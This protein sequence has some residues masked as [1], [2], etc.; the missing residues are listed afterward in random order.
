MD[1]G[2]RRH[3]G[4]FLAVLAASTLAA[5]APAASA[6][7][8]DAGDTGK[9]VAIKGAPAPGPAAYDRVWVRKYGPAN[10]G[11]VLILMPGS[12]SGQGSFDAI[13]PEI[14]ERVPGLAVWTLDRRGNAFEDVSAFEL[15]D[16]NAA[17]SYYLLEQ[18]IGGR[19]FQPV[20]D[21]DARFVRKW[22]AAVAMNDVHRV[23][24]RAGRRG[25]SVILGGHSMGASLTPLY[26]AWD[27]R[28]R[29]G[30]RDLD[31]LVQI[32]GGAM[33]TWQKSTAGTPFADRI[34]SVRKAKRVLKAARGQSP[35]GFA[36]WIEGVPEWLVGVLPELGCQYA[37]QAP[38]EASVFQ[39]LADEVEAAFPGVLPAGLL[40]EFPVTNEA[41]IGYLMTNQSSAGIALE[42]L[43]A[44]VGQLAESGDPRPW[45][46][47]PISSV[48]VACQSFTSE[49]GNA[50]EWYYPVRLE[51][52]VL[53]GDPYLSGD[54]ASRYLGMRAFHLSQVDVPVYAYE[55]A[56]SEGGVRK[57]VRRFVRKSQVQRHKVVSE[58]DAG[59][60]DP[61]LDD[62]AQNLFLETVVPFLRSVTP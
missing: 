59:H 47:G 31:G 19:K 60:L 36:G 55:S 37:L 32:D 9:R 42:S 17:L 21:R 28:G 13:A 20:S 49:P 33:G 15:G 2:I 50:F 6:A 38:N 52:D 7:A 26:A 62:P 10:A 39:R 51:I 8:G 58:P 5:L 3:A 54:A 48:P 11:A 25:R 30:F 41:F 12:P 45:V 35:F 4:R 27:F 61:L 1:R 18:E 43:H 29:A 40:P 16:A 53:R 14:A 22:G 34:G 23:V 46:N 56:I 24:K 57:G 44:R